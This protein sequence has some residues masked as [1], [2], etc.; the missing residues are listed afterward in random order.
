MFKL[1][2]CDRSRWFLTN[3]AQESLIPLDQQPGEAWR[4]HRSIKQKR[5]NPR[6]HFICLRRVQK[7]PEN[8][9]PLVTNRLQF[10]TEVALF[11][12]DQWKEIGKTKE[13]KRIEWFASLL[14]INCKGKRCPEQQTPRKL[15]EDKKGD[16]RMAILQRIQEKVWPVHF[17]HS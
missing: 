1:L 4:K 2:K 5:F 11:S 9:G 8:W 13:A 16:W 3:L 6:L 10:G 17:F 7:L 12:Q 14:R 15:R